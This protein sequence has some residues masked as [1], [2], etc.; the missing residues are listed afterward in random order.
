MICRQKHTKAADPPKEPE[1][2]PGSDDS[3][4]AEATEAPRNIPSA[5]ELLG[6]GDASTL[7]YPAISES[8]KGIEVA[9][10]EALASPPE[11]SVR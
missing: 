2:N 3:I 10:T 11:N 5:A 8:E 4:E 6:P 1:A 7:N 9:D